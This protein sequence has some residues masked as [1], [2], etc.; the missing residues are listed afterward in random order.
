MQFTL[1]NCKFCNIW[2]KEG[3]YSNSRELFAST[4]ATNWISTTNRSQESHINAYKSSKADQTSIFFHY[5]H[6]KVI[7]HDIKIIETLQKTLTIQS[8]IECKLTPVN[9]LSQYYWNIKKINIWLPLIIK[10]DFFAFI[11]RFTSISV[12]NWLYWYDICSKTQFIMLIWIA[13]LNL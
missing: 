12:L 7:S 8:W 2:A 10:H 5:R 11:N 13:N 9:P 6:L 1:L 4:K 3:H